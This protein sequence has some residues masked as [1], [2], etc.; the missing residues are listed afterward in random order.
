M[1]NSFSFYSLAPSAPLDFNIEVTKQSQKFSWKRPQTPN[2]VIRSYMLELYDK[3]T[4]KV[5][6]NETIPVQ[7]HDLLQVKTFEIGQGLKKYHEYRA[8]LRAVTVVPGTSA[9]NEFIS[10]QGRE[11]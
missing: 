3:K 10:V 6:F 2:G 5:I 8:L 11:Y 1:I 4:N 7:K 9:E